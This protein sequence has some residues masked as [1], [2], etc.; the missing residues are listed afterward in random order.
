MTP[1]AT[2]R[3]EETYEACPRHPAC[4]GFMAVEWESEA[5]GVEW[6]RRLVCATCGASRPHDPA[7]GYRHIF[8]GPGGD[9]AINWSLEQ[10]MAADMGYACHWQPP[11]YC[12]CPMQ[13]DGTGRWWL[14]LGGGLLMGL[15]PELDEFCPYC[16]LRIAWVR[17]AASARQWRA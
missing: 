12:L 8:T 13:Q 9:P 1:E 6:P 14:V 17:R 4:G 7:A 16:R 3:T 2:W 5:E 11:G 10:L 15:D